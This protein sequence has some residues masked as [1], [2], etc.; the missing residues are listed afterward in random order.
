MI[1]AVNTDFAMGVQNVVVF[2]NNTY[3]NNM[4]FFVVKKS[5]V[6]YFA[7]FNKAQCFSYFCLLS[8]ISRYK[9]A[10]KSIDHLSQSRAINSKRCFSSPEIR[11][12]EVHK[13]G[14]Q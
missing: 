4:P 3:M 6:A 2:H 9:I 13:C 5:Q 11:C 8:G 12:I 7:F 10:T 1:E 14:F